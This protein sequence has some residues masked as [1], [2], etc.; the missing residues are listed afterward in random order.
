M[1]GNAATEKTK[2]VFFAPGDVQ[3]ARVDRQCIVYA[4]DALQRLG[5]EVELVAMKIRLV[6][7]ELRGGNPLELYRLRTAP[8]LR[9]VKCLAGQESSGFW[10]A[11]NRFLVHGYAALRHRRAALP[12][13]KLIFYTKNY[14]SAWLF[15]AMRRLLIPSLKVIFEAHTVPH[16]ACQTRVLKNVDGIVA[17]CLALADDLRPILP[18]KPMMGIHQGVDLEH[19]NSLRISR[20]EAR[21]QLGL[22]IDTR[23][24]VYTG[25]LYWG[26]REV[27][28]LL[29]AARLL[30]P[31]IELTL[32]GG[33][34]DH[35]RKYE[36]YARQRGLANV[37]V[38]GFVPPCEV[39]RYQLAADVL[40]SYYPT[41]LELNR[42][43]SPGKLFEYMAAGRAIVAGDYPAL[44]EVVDESAAL[45]V[46]PD[47]PAALAAALNEL[48]RDEGRMT[49]LGAATLKR[50]E[51]FT[52]Q[53]RAEKILAFI[54][55]L[56]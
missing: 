2:F 16:N 6:K 20:E 9:L 35:A 24:V 26:Y 36:E 37:R 5:V 23:S 17:N 12:D 43:R 49:A 25:K 44:R 31:G 40:V 11:A 38:V 56:P 27:E 48:L 32:V 28:L 22:P 55:S 1:D 7:S 4:C 3:V 19:Y 46:Q 41:G 21:R 33:R 42:Y 45:F 47:H 30:T 8:R 34:A 51:Q 15:V 13:R 53:G 10:A 54:E 39:Q 14:S 52:W 29:E 50:V 18:G